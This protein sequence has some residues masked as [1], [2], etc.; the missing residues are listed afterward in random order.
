MQPVY[1]LAVAYALVGRRL[2]F[3]VTPK[4]VGSERV[5]PLPVFRQHLVMAALMATAV[6]CGF[7]LGRTGWPMLAWATVIVAAMVVV[8][9]LELP[10]RVTAMAGRR[11]AAAV[12]GRHRA[13]H[14]PVRW[15]LWGRASPGRR[16]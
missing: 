8:P 9:L 14:L 2:T 15:S 10:T 16:A 6:V 1:A 5:T 3:K 4:G 12:V 7:M 13:S 11:P